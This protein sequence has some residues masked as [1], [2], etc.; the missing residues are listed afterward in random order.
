MESPELYDWNEATLAALFEYIRDWLT[1]EIETSVDSKICGWRKLIHDAWMETRENDDEIEYGDDEGP[2]Q[3]MIS[4]N[5]NE[6][7]SKVEDLSLL[8]LFDEDY[9]MDDL[10]ADL[11]ADQAREVKRQLAISD[12]YYSTA[13]PPF[14]A[15]EQKHLEEYFEILKKEATGQS[16]SR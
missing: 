7:S 10:V 4:K 6:W 15:V 9:E 8:F 1:F 2:H 12:D 11:P 3:S 5:V 16:E 14:T 13:P